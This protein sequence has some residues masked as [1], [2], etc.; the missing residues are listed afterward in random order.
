MRFTVFS[1]PRE[2]VVSFDLLDWASV[3]VG[4]VRCSVN[5][6]E[7]LLILRLFNPG[8]IDQ[9]SKTKVILRYAINLNT[10]VEFNLR[11]FLSGGILQFYKEIEPSGRILRFA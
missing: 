9:V 10:K 8:M 5:Y 2:N 4:C 6:T 7:T 1:R 3:V 11:K